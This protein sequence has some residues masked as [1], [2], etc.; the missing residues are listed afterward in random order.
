[1]KR[2]MAAD[3]EAG[4]ERG[5]TGDQVKSFQDGCNKKKHT[6]KTAARHRR[7][8]AELARRGGEGLASAAYRRVSPATASRLMRIT[9]HHAAAR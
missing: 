5:L 7:L 6:H 8:A 9:P 1:M 4:G 2:P 3:R